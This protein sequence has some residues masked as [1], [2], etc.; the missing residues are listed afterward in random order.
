M[1]HWFNVIASGR[2][3]AANTVDELDD[4]GFV[5]IPGPVALPQLSRLA[6]VYDAGSI[7]CRPRRRRQRADD[8][9]SVGLRQ[10]RSRLR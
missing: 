9:A 6:A 5:V 3:L 10:S 7:G 2:E 1:D 4:V 8:D